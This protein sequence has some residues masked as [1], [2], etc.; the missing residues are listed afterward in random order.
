MLHVVT[1]RFCKIELDRTL[2]VLLEIVIYQ[3]DEPRFVKRGLE[4]VRLLS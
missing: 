4:C 2:P 1:G 3:T